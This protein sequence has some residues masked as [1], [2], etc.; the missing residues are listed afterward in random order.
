MHK[1]LPRRLVE[2][3][4]ILLEHKILAR[5]TFC[6]RKLV[7]KN[8]LIREDVQSFLDIVATHANVAQ[9]VLTQNSV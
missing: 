7:N 1:E 3:C 6:E 5:C 2:S 8:V 4:D 9:A